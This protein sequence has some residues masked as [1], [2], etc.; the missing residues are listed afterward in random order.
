MSTKV[1]IY[2]KKGGVGKTTITA[3]YAKM[4]AQ[5]DYRILIVDTD[6][7]RNASLYLGFELK[8]GM[9]DISEALISKSPKESIYEVEKNIDYMFLMDA[10][11][12]EN[13]LAQEYQPDVLY[14]EVFDQLKDDYDYILFDCPPESTKNTF[15]TL[16]YVDHIVVPVEPTIAGQQAVVD[17]LALLSK[18][19]RQ[20][21]S[22]IIQIIP[23]K[24]KA[25]TIVSRNH[26]EEIQALLD[27]SG[28][29][30]DFNNGIPHR[31]MVQKL[32]EGIE[33]L[34]LKEGNDLSHA[35]YC[36]LTDFLERTGVDLNG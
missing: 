27:E 20:P 14:K 8:G 18:R 21:V 5:L 22:K 17:V 13:I 34:Q 29:N 33:V 36:L 11:K 31:E 1:A 26:L 25:N 9:K 15:S 32:N 7:Q 24:V 12:L 16:V 3:L 2:N 23:N 30:L 6:A 4:L 28:I 10:S 35:L 19:L